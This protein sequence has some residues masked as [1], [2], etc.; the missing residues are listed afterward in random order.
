M[1]AIGKPERATQNRVVALFRNRLGYRY[2]GDWSDRQNNRPIE[3]THLT[4]WLANRG[5]SAA[6][7]SRVLDLLGREANKPTRSLYENNQAV[8]GLLRY[9]VAVKTEAGQNTVS[10]RRR[11]PT[12]SARSD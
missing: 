9:G 4:A 1:N 2:L 7:S 11:P 6:Q 12:F 8:Y 10:L 5:H 3:E